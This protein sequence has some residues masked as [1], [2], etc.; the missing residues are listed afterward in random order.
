VKENLD[1]FKQI[2]DTPFLKKMLDRTLEFIHFQRF[3]AR[4]AN[5]MNSTRFVYF[6]AYLG[7]G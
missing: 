7:E 5:Y 4:N 6:C 2:L 1:T 3:L